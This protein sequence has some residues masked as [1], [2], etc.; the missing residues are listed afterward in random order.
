M[1]TQPPGVGFTPPAGAPIFTPTPPHRF[2]TN[3]FVPATPTASFHP[4]YPRQTPL[5]RA[6]SPSSLRSLS[7]R[8]KTHQPNEATRKGDP[9][10]DVATRKVARVTAPATTATT[11]TNLH[12]ILVN[13]PKS[14]SHILPPTATAEAAVAA[15]VK[16]DEVKNQTTTAAPPPMPP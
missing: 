7:R 15:A 4:A 6:R 1:F 11:A 9:K 16:S 12:K 13:A 2:H 8:R 3:Y 14:V 5:Q 10:A